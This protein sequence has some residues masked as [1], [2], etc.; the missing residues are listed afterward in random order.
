MGIKDEFCVLIMG[1]SQGA[2]TINN[3]AIGLIGKYLNNKKCEDNFSN[4]KEKLCR[5]ERIYK[6][7][8]G[9]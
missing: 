1:G 5:C 3:A 6:K 9:A 7:Q 4:R 2:K 8:A